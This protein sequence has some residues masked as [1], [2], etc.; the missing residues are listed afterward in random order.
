[1]WV[2][3]NEGWGQ[4][5]TPRLTKWV[6]ELDPTPAGQQ[7][8]RLDTTSTVGD[9]I[10]MHTYPG[11]DSPAPEETR[12]AVL[13]EFGGLGLGLDG[14]K[15]VDKSWGY[16]GMPDT[17]HADAQVSRTVAEACGSCATRRASRRPST[18]RSPTSKPSATGC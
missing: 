9:V 4:Y 13:G 11:P 8:Q 3:F 14:H 16:R 17:P 2:V 12:A 5:D 15:W 10:D 7:R 1:M 18:R 6:K